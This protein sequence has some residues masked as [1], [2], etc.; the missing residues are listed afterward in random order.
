MRGTADQSCLDAYRSDADDASGEKRRTVEL[1]H[2]RLRWQP[3][4]TLFGPVLERAA[5]LLSINH[6]HLS[7]KRPVDAILIAV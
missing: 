7:R 6:H 1:G 5:Q 2:Y 4:R 3:P